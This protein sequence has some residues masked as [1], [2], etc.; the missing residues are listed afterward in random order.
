VVVKNVDSEDSAV[1]FLLALETL[2]I[3]HQSQV[4]PQ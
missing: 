3:F 1:P 4:T 2:D